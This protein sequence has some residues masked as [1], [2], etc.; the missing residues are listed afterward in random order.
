MTDTIQS[1]AAD[2][3]VRLGERLDAVDAAAEGDSNDAEIE[4]LQDALAFAVGML[5][6]L[7]VE[8]PRA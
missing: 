6:D 4:A 5:T 7:G 1:P 8:I 2:E 3:G